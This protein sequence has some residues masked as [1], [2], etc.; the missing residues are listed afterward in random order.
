MKTLLHI[1]LLQGIRQLR[2]AGIFPTVLLLLGCFLIFY[3][4]HQLKIESREERLLLSFWC[5]SFLWGIQVARKDKRFLEMLYPEHFSNYIRLEYLLFSLP[6]TLAF[7]FSPVKMIAFGLVISCL[8]V[9]IVKKTIEL[10]KGTSIILLKALIP[11]ANF[12][13]NAG[14][15]KHQYAILLL[16]VIGVVLS[17]FHVVG[18]LALSIICFITNTFF[19]E[20]ESYVVLTLT[21]QDEKA[22]LHHKLGSQLSLFL[23][24]TSPLLV[25][26]LLQYP[27][28][29][30]VLMALYSTYIVNY[31]VFILSKYKAYYPNTKAT[32]NSVLLGFV[33]LSL[34]VPFFLPM[35][36]V[37]IGLYY[38]KALTHLRPYFR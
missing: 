9:P 30:I 35:S 12:E 24:I 4:I 28:Y 6:F 36:F 20:S 2:K 38:K 5:G 16:Y 33:I 10:K 22:F 7:L 31:L 3:K 27:Q 34:L 1:R 11:P 18:F 8:I 15:R 21:A 32:G 37:L 25:I 17:F 13:W 19:Q 29:W 26:Y 23:K 14:M